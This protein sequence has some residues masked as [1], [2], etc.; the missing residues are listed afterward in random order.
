MVHLQPLIV[1]LQSSGEID[2]YIS[3]RYQRRELLVWGYK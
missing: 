2:A 1:S 3:A